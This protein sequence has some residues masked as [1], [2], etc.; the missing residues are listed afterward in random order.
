MLKNSISIALVVILTLLVGCDKSDKINTS[1]DSYVNTSVFSSSDSISVNSSDSQEASNNSISSTNSVLSSVSQENS[2]KSTN[3]KSDQ[4]TE[5]TYEILNVPDEDVF[6][7]PDFQSEKFIDTK[8]GKTLPYRLFVP[9][10]YSESKKYPVFF[11]LHGAGERGSD[12]TV[13]LSNF[14]SSFKTAGDVLKHSIIIAPQCP[15]YGWWNI[16]EQYGDENG[17]LGVAMRLL[18]KIQADYSTDGDRIYVTGLSMGGYATW[19]VLE[20]YPTVFA[21]G[22]PVCGWGNIYAADILKNIPIWIYHGTSDDTVSYTSSKE[23]YNAI[24][25]AG[26]C[27]IEFTTLH[28]VA[29]NAWDYSYT[30]RNMFCWLF[31][32]RKSKAKM[33]DASYE[34]I[35]LFEIKSPQDITVIS[36]NDITYISYE[37]VNDVNCCFAEL[38]DD[39]QYSIEKAYKNNIGKTFTVYY[40]GDPIYTFKPSRAP[41]NNMVFIDDCAKM[42]IRSVVSNYGKVK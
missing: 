41:V 9:K 33:G 5:V 40:A 29:H 3:S 26:G 10:N 34:Y 12:N 35:P 42:I 18:N 1:S 7:I 20:R 11:F 8:S 14:K 23:M 16:D 4:I 37:Y 24:K 17:W 38:T 22:V 32:Q 13:Q 6:E 30:D 2:S 28:G 27:M 19:S 31:S 39:G 36:E 21:A 15:E 25:S